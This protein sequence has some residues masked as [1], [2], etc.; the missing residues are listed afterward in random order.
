[1]SPAQQ[2]DTT[3]FSSLTPPPAYEEVPSINSRSPSQYIAPILQ[4]AA[5]IDADAH[6]AED[7]QREEQRLSQEAADAEFARRLMDEEER[8]NGSHDFH[9]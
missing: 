2:A 3:G 7:L 6:F 1:M 8:V 4:S 5:E 9:F